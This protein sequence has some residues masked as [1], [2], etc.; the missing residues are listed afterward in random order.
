MSELH[1]NCKIKYIKYPEF[2]SR[3]NKKVEKY[4]N[5]DFYQEMEKE[6]YKLKSMEEFSAFYKT[7]NDIDNRWKGKY[8]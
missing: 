5:T 2:I 6:Y 4:A 8:R 7:L 1:E 3:F